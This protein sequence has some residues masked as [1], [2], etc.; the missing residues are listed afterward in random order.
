MPPTRTRSRARRPGRDRG[1][2]PEDH[3]ED[4]GTG[5]VPVARPLVQVEEVLH[6][7]PADAARLAAAHPPH[8][9]QAAPRAQARG[10]RQGD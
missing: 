1:A 9:P 8:D 5:S 4:A 7:R 2:L 3:R 10:P 6:D